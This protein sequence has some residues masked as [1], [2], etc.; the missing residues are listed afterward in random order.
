M[1]SF[2]TLKNI[3]KTEMG[4]KKNSCRKSGMKKEFFLDSLC[5]LETVSCT[6]I[7]KQEERKHFIRSF[8]SFNLVYFTFYISLLKTE[9]F[10]K[11]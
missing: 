4:W 5:Y 11:K 9:I 6:K 2:G 8:L 10:I 3:F 1:K 7:N